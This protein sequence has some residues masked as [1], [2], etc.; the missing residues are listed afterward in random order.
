MA[1][2]YISALYF[3]LLCKLLAQYP[4]HTAHKSFDDTKITRMCM[5]KLD[6]L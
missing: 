1:F 3:K 4:A 5:K 2:I 6:D